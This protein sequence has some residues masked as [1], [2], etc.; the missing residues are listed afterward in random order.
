MGNFMNDISITP[1]ILR[2]FEL[3]KSN[4]GFRS[5]RAM[6]RYLNIP[7]TTF[8][9][10]K[11][12]RALTI[13]G[14]IAEEILPTLK[15]YIE[16]AESEQLKEGFERPFEY[17]VIMGVTDPNIKIKLNK[18]YSEF[19]KGVSD[20][21]TEAQTIREL[22]Q[23]HQ[24]II[25][26][27]YLSQ[28]VSAGNGLIPSEEK[29]GERPDMDILTVSGESM[30]PAF[31]NG[32]KVIVHTFQERVK[33]GEDHLPLDIVKSLIPEDTVI[34][35]NRNDTGLAMKRV[36]YQEKKS[37]WY[38]KLTADN[39]EWAKETGFNSII[40]KSDDFEI[41]GKVIGKVQ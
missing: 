2:A 16:Q 31:N 4:K 27:P 18:L 25:N 33:F 8:G 22:T 15:P 17:K 34:I 28:E 3:L 21:I 19:T 14:D 37:A 9:N 29:F 40:K 24:P 41:F 11:H 20:L 23:E 10:W 35:Y 7:V 1:L 13:N 32:D 6:C 38:F 30:Q 26:F 12:K 39:T 5:E 36:K